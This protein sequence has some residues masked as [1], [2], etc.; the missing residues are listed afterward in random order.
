[1]NNWC[2]LNRIP[3]RLFY[4]SLLPYCLFE[5]KKTQ[6]LFAN[7]DRFSAFHFVSISF[8]TSKSAAQWKTFQSDLKVSF[9]LHCSLHFDWNASEK[10]GRARLFESNKKE[11]NKHPEMQ[12]K[13]SQTIEMQL[14]G[15]DFVQTTFSPSTEIEFPLSNELFIN[16]VVY[17]KFIGKCKSFFT[18]FCSWEIIYI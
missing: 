15:Q 13:S 3:R 1:M 6:L 16:K 12:Q 4:S 14:I 11:R 8:L 10:H 9:F 7:Y 17:C 18:T 5:N 2:Q